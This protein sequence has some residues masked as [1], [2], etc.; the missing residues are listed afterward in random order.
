MTQRDQAYNAIRRAILKGEVPIGETLSERKF[1]ETHLPD[2]DLGRTPI[3]EA[4]AVLALRGLVRQ[5]P[6]VG[7]D[8][9]PVTA[10]EATRIVQIRNAMER[11]VVEQL[12]T[13]LTESGIG[14]TVDRMKRAAKDE[15]PFEFVTA[16]R[17][18]HIEICVQADYRA[19][20]QSVGAFYDRLQLFFLTERKPLRFHEME[21]LAGLY[22]QLIGSLF[23]HDVYGAL[24]LFD[25]TAK[26]EI[27]MIEVREQP[28]ERAAAIA[29]ARAGAVTAA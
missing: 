28:E 29:A 16:T 4:L 18:F 25:K 10:S 12:P 5:L 21:T 26:E 2:E 24:R 13:S 3:R 1:T 6:Q 27:Q 17:D 22:E 8:V 11:V 23:V 20:A 7:F 19:E 15:D 14:G 9:P